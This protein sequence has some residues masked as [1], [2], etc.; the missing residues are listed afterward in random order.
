VS[1][2]SPLG[3]PFNNLKNTSS[4]RLLK[5]RIQKDRPGSPCHKKFLTFN[6]EFT[7]QSICT[8]SRQYQNLK[9]KELEQTTTSA[10]EFEEKSRIVLEK[11]CLCEGL[12]IPA[13]L[14]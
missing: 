11:E 9:L 6:T 5:E 10:E 8:A 12:A 13:A 14:V 7:E 3:V 2:A 4:Q 1:D